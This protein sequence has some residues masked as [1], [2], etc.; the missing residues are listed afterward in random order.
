M[1]PVSLVLLVL[2]ATAAFG[3]YGGSVLNNQPVI[4]EFASHVE[5]ASV[6]SLATPQYI[7]GSSAS[8]SA[9]GVT[10][11][12][13]FPVTSEEVSLGEVA[14]QLRKQH[15]LAKKAQRVMTDQK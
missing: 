3:Q 15:E 7:L 6:Q 9:R 12:W 4:T 10:P 14:R 5:H 1:K 8:I 13:E 2:C 11:L